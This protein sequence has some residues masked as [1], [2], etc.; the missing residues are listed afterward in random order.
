MDVCKRWQL[1]S[2]QGNLSAKI[3]THLKTSPLIAQLLL[4]RG[5]MSLTDA[6]FF[7]GTAV[8]K[9]HFAFPEVDLARAA[10]ILN[11]CIQNNQEILLYGDYDVD[12]MTSVTLMLDALNAC[13]A[14]VR[15]IIPD[16]FKD[17]YGLNMA[18]V[19]V[20]KQE[21]I[22]LLITLDCGVSSFAEVAA[23]N[24]LGTCKVMIFD[25]HQIPDKPTQCAAMLNPK[26]LQE[27]NPAFSLC[28][29]GIAYAFICY[30]YQKFE[31]KLNPELFLDLVALGTIADV[32][33]LKG[34]NREWTKAGLKVLAKSKRPGIQH[35]IACS[36]IKNSPLTVRDVG[37]ALG[38]RLNAAGRLAS[39]T[40]GVRLLTSQH[41]DDASRLAFQL[42]QLNLKRREIG[43]KMLEE[44]IILRENSDHQDFVTVLGSPSWHAGVVGITA[45]RLVEQFQCPAILIAGDGKIARAS[46]RSAGV[47]NLYQL[48]KSCQSF[49][50]TFG[51]HRQAAGFSIDWDDVP[52]FAKALNQEA[53][54]L[55]PEDFKSILEIDSPIQAQDL[56]LDLAQ[57]LE[58]LAPFGV[59][60]QEP[61]F[62]S[63]QLKLLSL[64]P[65]GNGDHLKC[66]LA[67][68]DESK[69]IDAIAFN[70]SEKAALFYKEPLQMV[71]KLQ[72]ND[73]QGRRLPQLEIVDIK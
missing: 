43:Q 18:I 21:N 67:T 36:K 53:A 37:F 14:R 46:A 22:S 64:K 31:P 44:A 45:A 28:T 50:K 42:D 73:W 35:L 12:G 63:D 54:K 65:V 61:L 48:L 68:F 40:L 71:F 23:I 24:K 6:K 26:T 52:A 72:I 16:R 39:A 59:A 13:G 57:S 17:G 58:Q 51:G 62:F 15:Y 49:F 32:A 19:D 20:I 38:P 25:H 30:F 27:S 29:V 10:K 56:S 9:E 70:L 66:T 8:P 33:D 60:N 2:Q 5:I 69:V 11:D 47:I 55:D 4:N 41:S 7:L 3:A 1:K 34:F